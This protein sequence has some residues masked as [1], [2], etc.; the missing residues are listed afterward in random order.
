MAMRRETKIDGMMTRWDDARQALTFE[1]ALYAYIQSS[2]N[3]TPWGDQI[4][5]ITVGKWAD[6]VVMDTKID[7]NDADSVVATQVLSTYL[8]GEAIYQK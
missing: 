3:L 7:V 5:S 6:F 1:E 8:A 4:G 2:A